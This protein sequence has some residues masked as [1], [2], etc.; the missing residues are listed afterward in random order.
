MKAKLTINGEE[1]VF[2]I[3]RGRNTLPFGDG[4]TCIVY[5][6]MWIG[7]PIGLELHCGG[8]VTS[9]YE[10]APRFSGE[11]EVSMVEDGIASFDGEWTT[12]PKCSDL[13][14]KNRWDGLRHTPQYKKCSDGGKICW[15]CACWISKRYTYHDLDTFHREPRKMIIVDGCVY[16]FLEK[17]ILQ[18]GQK[19][20]SEWG[21]GFGGREFVIYLKDEGRMVRTNNL[22]QGGDVPKWDRENWPDN[23]EFVKGHGGVNTL[24][25][26]P[27]AKV[28]SKKKET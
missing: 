13:V 15:S 16:S 11:I 2:E 19:A 1:R 12:C 3:G 10:E 8:H 28:K 26:I 18:P 5:N 24:L 7:G 14:E 20:R 22:W 17:D 6:R 9:V 21:K 27:E 4:E 23:A 25:A